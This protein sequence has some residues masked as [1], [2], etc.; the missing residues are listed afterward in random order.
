MAL[1]NVKA[2]TDR[3]RSLSGR[4]RRND[5][6]STKLKTADGSAPVATQS[7]TEKKNNSRRG[8]KPN[9]PGKERKTK[10]SGT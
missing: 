7:Q 6:E 5:T 2:I 1:S 8:K 10:D 4:E 3:L 9:Q